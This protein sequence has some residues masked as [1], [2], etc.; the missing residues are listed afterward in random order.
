M[1]ERS[2]R[3]EG[4]LKGRYFFSR[5]LYSYFA[6]GSSWFRMASADIGVG[7]REWQG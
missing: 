2:C 7:N 4:S 3:A 6:V 5:G 1:G